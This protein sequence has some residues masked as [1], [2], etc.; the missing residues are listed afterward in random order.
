MAYPDGLPSDYTQAGELLK[1]AA[2][3]VDE[4][5]LRGRIRFDHRVTSIKHE[6][7]GV[8]LSCLTNGSQR[9]TVKAK[10]VFLS[11]GAQVKP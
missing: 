7:E 4:A 10:A 9:C 3:F 11:T 8:M 2:R 6:Q 1:N 5:Q